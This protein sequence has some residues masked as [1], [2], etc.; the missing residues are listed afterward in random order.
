[1]TRSVNHT[2]NA[3]LLKIEALLILNKY[4]EAVTLIQR[5]QRGERLPLTVDE[6]IKTFLNSLSNKYVS[7]FN[8]LYPY[9]EF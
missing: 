3:R 8:V 6:K 2:V 5:I 4:N 7:L 9:Y 1:L